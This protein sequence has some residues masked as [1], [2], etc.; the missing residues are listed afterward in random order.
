MDSDIRAL[1]REFKHFMKI[2]QKLLA[3]ERY[4]G[5]FVAM[6]DKTVIDVGDDEY[7]LVVKM[8]ERYPDDVVLVKKVVPATPVYDLSSS[9]VIR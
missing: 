2:K 8:S 1:R 4:R 9:E 5:R 7:E 3:D 6:K